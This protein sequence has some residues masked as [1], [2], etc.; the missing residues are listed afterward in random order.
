MKNLSI[1]W[2]VTLIG[3]L[4]VLIVS[5]FL[6]FYSIY[7]IKT[8]SEEQE[9]VFQEKA[10]SEKKKTLED[11]INLA[12]SSIKKFYDNPDMPKEEAQKK[13]LDVISSMRYD[14][15]NYIFI[16][17]YDGLAIY[18]A[19]EKLIGKN[20]Y[21]LQDSNGKYL[22]HHIIDN[23]KNNTHISDY[24]WK[25]PDG[26]E[27]LKLTYSY[28]LSKWGWVIGTGFF[29]D[30]VQTQVEAMRAET[31]LNV[32]IIL[33][34]I[35]VVTF[36]IVAVI[37]AISIIL[38]NLMTKSIVTT[39]EMLKELSEGEGDL[40]KRLDVKSKDEI[41]RMS[42]HFNTFMDKLM[43]II[44][45]AKDN[46]ASV[47]SGSAELA[48]T[49]EELTSTVHSQVGQITDVA[50]AA[51]EL[52]ASATEVFGSLQSGTETMKRT[53]ETGEAGKK[54]LLDAVKEVNGINEKVEEL[55]ITINGLETSSKEIGEI[56]NVISDIADQ[57]NLLALNAAIE[58]ARAGDHGRGF[59]VVADEVR[60]LAEKTQGSTGQ[61]SQII[62]N[63][64][65]DSRLAAEN[66]G[67][68]KVQ[69]DKGV[70]SIKKTESTFEEISKSI[71]M[72]ND[73]NGIIAASINEQT[74]TIEEVT[75]NIQSIT[76]GLEES[77]SALGQVATTVADLEQQSD[78]LK[79]TVNRFKTS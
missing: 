17:A 77:S 63:L 75:R 54:Q 72:V 52:N 58:A 73:V 2:K 59:A 44:N 48:A 69:V 7:E 38:A 29:I 51:E 61:I 68:A 24:V 76:S 8:M 42:R 21:D 60:K 50:A 33:R 45:L 16:N 28:D 20:L 67:S 78:E 70:V 9:Q 32:K 11:Y 5:I 18:N 1:K 43:E 53:V 62:N 71:A 66:M 57:T 25:K 27:A 15:D 74:S 40:T 49:T 56:I 64:Q 23:A 26:K 37:I 36:F 34:N 12:S 65:R 47:A 55:Q 22:F 35:V 79:M 19:N 6:A 46:A 39:T 31:D 10:M 13:A 4:P 3:V 30:D 41:G 14:G